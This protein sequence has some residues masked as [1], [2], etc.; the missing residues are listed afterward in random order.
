MK[1]FTHASAPFGGLLAREAVTGGSSKRLFCCLLGSVNRGLH[2]A[3]CAVLTTNQDKRG[4]P[5]LSSLSEH[6]SGESRVGGKQGFKDPMNL[7]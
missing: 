1:P 3:L 4:E 5:A 2:P 6:L 7:A